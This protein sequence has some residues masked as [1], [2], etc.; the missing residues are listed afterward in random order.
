[1]IDE[2]TIREVVALARIQL[3]REERDSL[4]DDL[5]QILSHME[6]LNQLDTGEVEP[7]FHPVREM[8]NVFRPDDPEPGLAQ[9]QLLALP[10]EVE[11][12]YIRVRNLMVR[13]ESEETP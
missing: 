5:E 6:H 11:A 12:P 7:T 8:K 4:K 1:M 13:E 2:G 9:D 10:A 3:T